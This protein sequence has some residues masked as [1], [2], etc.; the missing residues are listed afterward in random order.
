[1]RKTFKE[2]FQKID[3]NFNMIFR[4]L[5]SEARRMSGWRMATYLKAGSI[6]RPTSGQKAAVH[7][8]FVGR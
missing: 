3:E 5:F 4:K 7:Y 8:A 1:M 2:E 6:S